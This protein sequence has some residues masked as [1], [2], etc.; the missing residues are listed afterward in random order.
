MSMFLDFSKVD[1]QDY[2]NARLFLSPILKGKKEIPQNWTPIDLFQRNQE[3]R[4]RANLIF[5]AQMDK[6]FPD[7]YARYLECLTLDAEKYRIV[8][9]DSYNCLLAKIDKA[10][11]AKYLSL[12]A[13]LTDEDQFDDAFTFQIGREIVDELAQMT[14][15]YPYLMD[16]EKNHPTPFL[17]R[18]MQLLTLDKME[19]ID[20]YHTFAYAFNCLYSTF[21]GIEDYRGLEP[22]A[23]LRDLDLSLDRYESDDKFWR[24]LNRMFVISSTNTTETNLRKWLAGLVMMYDVTLY[25]PDSMYPSGHAIVL[26][27]TSAHREYDALGNGN[28]T[29]MFGKYR[30]WLNDVLVK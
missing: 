18:C 30:T 15:K 21:K 25:P 16:L 26:P 27:S 23:M 10:V 2:K 22:L 6:Q 20:Y 5:L 14:V 29:N 11:V 24:I 3:T 7:L 8:R 19:R 13:K 1:L 28:D 17:N 4:I 12:R 9:Q